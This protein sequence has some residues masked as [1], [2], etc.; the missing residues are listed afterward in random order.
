MR[1][2]FE[3]FLIV[4]GGI[5]LGLFVA[6][7]IIQHFVNQ[8][9]TNKLDDDV[10]PILVGIQNEMALYVMEVDGNHYLLFAS[11]KRDYPY[12]IVL[13]DCMV[14]NRVHEYAEADLSEN[15][16]IV[17]L[18]LVDYEIGYIDGSLL[19]RACKIIGTRPSKIIM[20]NRKLD[21]GSF[22]ELKSSIRSKIWK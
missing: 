21:K 8:R 7:V 11:D 22:Y 19:D 4:F 12:L 17:N 6:G 5:V 13:V 18:R 9:H 15:G 16:K 10:H 2:V 3:N 1:R 20:E 14:G